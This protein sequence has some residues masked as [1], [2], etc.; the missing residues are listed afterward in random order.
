MNDENRQDA[1]CRLEVIGQREDDGWSVNVIP[2]INRVWPRE[3]AFR[4]SNL[5]ASWVSLLEA[6]GSNSPGALKAVRR[7][8]V[9][10]KREAHWL[11]QFSGGFREK[12]SLATQHPLATLDL[13]DAVVTNSAEDVP[14]HL[15]E[16]LNLVVEAD[17]SLERD[18]RFLRLIDLTEQT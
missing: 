18:R 13:L 11:Y 15:A 4:T 5:V 3:R 17:P 8:L 1:V 10:V 7:F 12:K 16:V 9:P 2:F 6:S 14:Y